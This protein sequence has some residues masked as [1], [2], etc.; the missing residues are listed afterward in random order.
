MMADILKV[1]K[2]LLLLFK[3]GNACNNGEYTMP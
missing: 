1:L 2:L 3:F